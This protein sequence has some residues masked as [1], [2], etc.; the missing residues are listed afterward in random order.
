MPTKE[1]ISEQLNEIL[2]LTENPIDFTRLNKE[3][4]ERLVDLFSTVAQV[5]QI[6]IRSARE[7]LRGGILGRP[8]EEVLRMPLIDVLA[9]VRGEGGLL[10]IVD[11]ITEARTTRSQRQTRKTK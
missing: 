11:R 1:Q 7:K 2:G 10:G 5:A 8:V 4:L 6:G 3:E 9:Q